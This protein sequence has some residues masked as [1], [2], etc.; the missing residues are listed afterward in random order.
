MKKEEM[1]QVLRQW[2]KWKKMGTKWGFYLV[3]G[4]TKQ[5]APNALC[6]CSNEVQIYVYIYIKD[7]VRFDTRTMI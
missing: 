3:Q 7:T 6:A 5:E 2:M 4:Q 1:Y